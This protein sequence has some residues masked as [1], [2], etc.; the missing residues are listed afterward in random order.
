M[1]PLRGI[2][3]K[4]LSW[5]FTLEDVWGHVTFSDHYNWTDGLYLNTHADKRE[6]TLTLLPKIL[7]QTF[8]ANLCK[9]YFAI[10]IAL[11]LTS[12]RPALTGDTVKS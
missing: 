3:W 2:L 5:Y 6:P 10:F 9:L 8:N 4:K 12:T 11:I 1:D 7:F